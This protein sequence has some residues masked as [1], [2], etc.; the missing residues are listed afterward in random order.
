MEQSN[1]IQSRVLFADILKIIA[2]FAVINIHVTGSFTI[3]SFTSTNINNWWVE[4]IYNS[5]SR[6]AV[7]VFLMVSG[8]FLLASK[9][10]EPLKIYF[11]KRVRKVFIPF[12]IWGGIYELIKPRYV[13]VDFSLKGMI[14]DFL[15][16]SIYWH[17]WFLYAIMM[18]YILVPI[19]R[20][21]ISKANKEMLIYAVSVWFAMASLIPLI[22]FVFEVEVN[23]STQI[24]FIGACVGYCVLGY[25]LY[26]YDFSKTFKSII[27]LLGVLSLI[28]TPFLTYYLTKN[29]GGNLN[30]FFYD[31]FSVNVVIVS[32]AVFLLF[33]SINWDVLF[34]KYQSK[35]NKIISEM[36]QASFGIFLIHYII[37]NELVGTGLTIFDLHTDSFY[38]VPITNITVFLVSLIIIILLRR[39]P[40]IKSLV[41]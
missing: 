18:I 8:M 10:D 28:L 22:K 31:Y 5:L 17:F 15:S 25:T 1:S 30:S 2:I 21:F 9:K 12:L 14:T 35:F 19:I 4:N 6:W 7:P 13:G 23:I 33:K 39:I 24:S 16:G 36:G 27:Y 37:L 32:S 40:V 38:R 3:V 34:G 29:N 26:K 20:T 41:P 11:K